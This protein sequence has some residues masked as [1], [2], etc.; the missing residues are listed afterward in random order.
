M[1]R[2]PRFVEPSPRTDADPDAPLGDAQHEDRTSA[3]DRVRAGDSPADNR[4]PSQREQLR[5]WS[6]I[7]TQSFG[8]GSATLFLMRSILIRRRRW[9]RDHEFLEDWTLSRL[10]PGVHLIALTSLLGRRIGGWWGVALAVGGMLVPA[11]VITA[12]MTATFGVLSAQPQI[13][14]ALAGMGPVTI[15]MMIGMTTILAR[16]AM[17]RGRNAVPD[18]LLLSAATVVG[19]LELTSPVVLILVGGVLGA[20]FLGQGESPHTPPDS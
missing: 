17:R 5:V 8:G 4:P 6:A 10:S 13:V 7:G 1:M 19:F 16:S 15:G 14:A 11:T 2:R 18:I 20:L 3:V 12:A 9:V